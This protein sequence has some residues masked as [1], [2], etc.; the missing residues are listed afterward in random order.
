MLLIEA[1]LSENYVKYGTFGIGALV[2]LLGS[3]LALAGVLAN[4]D[5]QN[6]LAEEEN[7]KSLL[8][9]RAALPPVLSSLYQKCS[10]A[11]EI[12]DNQ[13][14]ERRNEKMA[15][16]LLSELELSS[17]ELKSLTE[18]IKHADADTARWLSLIIS[19]FQIAQARL[20]RHLLN[21][22]LYADPPEDNYQSVAYRAVDWLEIKALVSHV[23]DFAR[24]G[25]L[26]ATELDTSKISLPIDNFGTGPTARCWDHTYENL[27]DHY[28]ENGG[29][30]SIGFQQRLLTN[31]LIS[32]QPS[33]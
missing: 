2:A 20:N 11:F 3:G 22:D 10:N 7:E 18:C 12:S 23:F 33:A 31:P 27:M 1:P 32:N 28:D 26:P 19:H 30:S 14:E 13:L 15:L 29:T 17:N 4:I 24:T 21:S 6:R 8:A 5:N 16:R 9:A 25:K